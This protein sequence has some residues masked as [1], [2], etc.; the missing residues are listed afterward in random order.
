MPPP[1]PPLFLP[2]N[3]HRGISPVP[4][5]VHK[6]QIKLLSGNQILDRRRDMAR[7]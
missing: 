6:F 2:D 1:P 7:T 3:I 4:D 5:R